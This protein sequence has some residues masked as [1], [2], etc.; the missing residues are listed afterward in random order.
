M[1]H[2]KAI[3]TT[4]LGRDSQPKYLGIK[5]SDGQTAKIGNVILRQRGT[6]YIAGTGVRVGRDHTIYAIANGKVKFA[7]KQ[8]LKQN[9]SRK[10]M[11]VVSVCP[12]TGN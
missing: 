1:A 12:A 10:V 8:M 5:L 4:S 2:T 7:T 3:G 6:R 9:G 11:K